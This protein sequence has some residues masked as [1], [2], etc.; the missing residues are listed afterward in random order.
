MA[1]HFYDEDDLKPG[2]AVDCKVVVN[3]KVEITEDDR[4]KAKEAALAEIIADQKNKLLK[5]N[6]KK[7]GK[8]TDIQP[9]KEQS[10]LF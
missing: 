9:V 10:S 4:S 5:R 2:K 8:K 7:L 3:H 6:A 1:V